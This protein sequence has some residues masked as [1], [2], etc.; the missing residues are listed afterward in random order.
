MRGHGVLLQEARLP[1]G[2]PADVRGLSHPTQPGPRAHQGWVAFSSLLHRNA[3]SFYVVMHR[4]AISPHYFP[5]YTLCFFVLLITLTQSG[6][7][8]ILL[9]RPHPSLLPDKRSPIPVNIRWV[10]SRFMFEA[11]I[12]HKHYNTIGE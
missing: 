10:F 3:F 5:S 4:S 1:R 8:S 9:I 6:S 2:E 11:P 12:I 7:R